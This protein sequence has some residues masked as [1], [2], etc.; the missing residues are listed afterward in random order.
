MAHFME[1]ARKP[2]HDGVRERQR[3][4]DRRERDR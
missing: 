4:R 3:E 2:F 1:R